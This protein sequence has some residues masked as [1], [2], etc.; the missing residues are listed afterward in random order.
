MGTVLALT[1]AKIDKVGA[2]NLLEVD[3]NGEDIGPA[4]EDY[5]AEAEKSEPGRIV[6]NSL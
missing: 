2:V 6:Q 4:K 3:E 1:Q 5:S